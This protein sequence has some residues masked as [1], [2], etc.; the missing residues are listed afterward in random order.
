MSHDR[1][2]SVIG[3]GYVGLSTAIAFS[4]VGK[5]IAIDISE[6]RIQELKNHYDRNYE[7]T[8]EEL[9]CP[10][11]HF[12]TNFEDLKDADFHIITVPTPLDNTKR[13]NFMMLLDASE[14][15]GN[16][17][18]YN[19]IV[20]Y[21]SS[22]YPGATE[23]RCVPVLEHA[24]RLLY[25]KDF[26]VGYS[27]ERINPADKEHTFTN[28]IKIISGTDQKTIDVLADV[29]KSVVKAGVYPVSTIRAAEATKVI[30]NTQRDVNIA[31]L[32]DVAVMLHMLNIDT[33][34]VI[35]AMKT[36]WNFVPF[37]PGLVGG[38]CI[39][40]NSYY[41]MYR[42]EEIGYYSPLVRSVRYI[43]E[44]I[45]TY[46][47]IETIRQLILLGVAV[48]R[49]RIAVLGLSYK[50]NCSD[51]RDTKVINVIHNLERFGAEVIVHDPLADHEAAKY[52]YGFHL[53]NWEDIKDVDAVLLTVAHNFYRELDKKQLIKKLN[54]RCLIMDLKNIFSPKDFEDTGIKLW[55][56]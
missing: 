48:K 1:K 38:H 32:N 37:E 46:I 53:V 18:K 51:V 22:V 34:E 6:Q 41:L 3:L 50:E 11:I 33:R 10:N 49:A 8:S 5:V 43:N 47:A 56:L 36:K 20:V 31:F 28:I 54:N 27:P 29:Y 55:K 30:E 9:N 25:G 39:G 4:K 2:V 12:T 44:N 24:S 35:D 40:I 13:P 16:Y 19:D 45:S 26:T 15:V 17:L 21:E 23:E 14:K 42:A 52:E 7:L